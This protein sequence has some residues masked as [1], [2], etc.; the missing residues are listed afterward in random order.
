MRH[1]FFLAATFGVVLALSAFKPIAAQDRF[2]L[3]LGH[4]VPAG[5]FFSQYL[6]SWANTLRERSDGRLKIT[7]FPGA[8]MGPT[9]RYYDM[10]AKAWSTSPGSCTARRPAASRSP[11]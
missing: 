9:P 2:E 10:R 4:Y 1:R 7:I 8:Q 11:S 3:K 6:E 5:H